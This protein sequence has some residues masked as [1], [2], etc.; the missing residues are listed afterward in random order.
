GEG[1]GT[2]AVPNPPGKKDLQTTADPKNG[3]QGAQGTGTAGAKG[4]GTGKDGTGKDGKVAVQP[5]KGPDAPAI[6]MPGL[7]RD[8]KDGEEKEDKDP[9]LTPPTH[10]GHDKDQED[11]EHDPLSK[12]PQPDAQGRNL[13]VQV[14]GKQGAAT[15]EVKKEDK[16]AT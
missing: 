7:Q 5:V 6:K 15:G 3:Q 13:Q 9:S 4:D 11:K 16:T 14:P 2:G 12:M 1:T 10:E 8:K